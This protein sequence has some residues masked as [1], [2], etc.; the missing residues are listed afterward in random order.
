MQNEKMP[1]FLMNFKHSFND[2]LP[3]APCTTLI[4]KGFSDRLI[5]RIVHKNQ[6][7]VNPVVWKR[8]ISHCKSTETFLLPTEKDE[9]PQTHLLLK[10]KRQFFFMETLS[11]KS[12]ESCLASNKFFT[13]HM[14]TFP[15]ATLGF[16]E[17][18]ITTVKL[19]RYRIND[20]CTLIHSVVSTY[21]PGITEP[22]IVHYQDEQAKK[23]FDKI[24]IQL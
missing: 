24:H 22:F 16:L 6:P 23:L 19:P 2:L 9:P 18:S 7:E 20:L 14:A 17:S 4:E 10:L 3:T 13:T 15:T 11:K 1:D 12:E 8:C 21:H 5:I